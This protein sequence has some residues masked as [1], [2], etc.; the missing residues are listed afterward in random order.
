MQCGRIEELTVVRW[1]VVV[2]GG[3][4]DGGQCSVVGLR[5]WL[6][7]DDVWLLVVVIVVQCDQLV[8]CDLLYGIL[9]RD[10]GPAT[11]DRG[12]TAGQSGRVV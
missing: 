4:G 5:D 10:T 9:S 12:V 8:G 3:D 6:W 2:V 1:H 7:L 11:Q